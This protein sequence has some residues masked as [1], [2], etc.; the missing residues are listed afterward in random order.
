[1]P[2]PGGA[3]LA[4]NRSLTH[5]SVNLCHWGISSPGGD[6]VIA[7]AAAA[8]T[9]GAPLNSLELNFCWVTAKGCRRLATVMDAGSPLREVTLRYNP[10]GSDGVAALAAAA[11]S[12]T[13]LALINDFEEEPA[14]GAL[15]TL[16]RTS[17]ALV[18]L[19]LSTEDHG[20]FDDPDDEMPD[21]DFD[22]DEEVLEA[23]AAAVAT[24]RAAAEGRKVFVVGDEQEE[25]EQ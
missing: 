6:I 17:D 12:L 16:V 4:N 18:E 10:L 1:M 2:L 15:D 19:D 23:R 24:L 20:T 13:K 8:I 14:L 3:G 7:A 21:V 22:D 11:Q 25:E 9:G 5:L